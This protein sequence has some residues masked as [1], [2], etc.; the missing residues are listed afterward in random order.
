MESSGLRK[1]EN[2]VLRRADRAQKA[3]GR[4]L[5]FAA[6]RVGKTVHFRAVV[7]AYSFLRVQRSMKF[8]SKSTPIPGA[9]GGCA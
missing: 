7:S 9:S 3:R 8:Q 5:P 2:L 6:L 4:F 1:S